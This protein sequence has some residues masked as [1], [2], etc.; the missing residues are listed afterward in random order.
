MGLCG[1]KI[2]ILRL[3][4]AIF[5]IFIFQPVRADFRAKIITRA[6]TL[7]VKIKEIYFLT[8]DPPY[9]LKTLPR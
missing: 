1:D 4:A 9:P 6:T 5:E 3:R 7:Y 2:G 8:L